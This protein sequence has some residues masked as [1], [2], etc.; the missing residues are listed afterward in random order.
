MLLKYMLLDLGIVK[1]K[2]IDE[3]PYTL[4]SGKKSRLFID[5]K[6]ASLD[7]LVLNTMSD[8]VLNIIDDIEIPD[9]IASVA[10]GG[11]PLATIVSYISEIPHIIIRSQK[12]DRG[13]ETKIIGNC[14]DKICLL[15]EDVA[16]S[17]GSI[18][19]AVNAI[20]EAGGICNKCIVVVDREE[21]A[22][23]LCKKNNIELTSLLT[24][25][26]FG[27]MQE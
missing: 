27:I 21:G 2:S 20:R 26:D 24:K 3:E 14:K 11:V 19:N 22:K 9:R 25:T 10:V 6:E 5:I 23:E 4:K 12:H 7:P 15:V 18:V 8:D 13:T 17:G 16:T 1:I